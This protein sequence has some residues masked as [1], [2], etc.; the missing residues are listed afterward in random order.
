MSITDEG[1][2][3]NDPKDPSTLPLTIVVYLDAEP[4]VP[5][6]SP[7]RVMTVSLNAAHDMIRSPS[8]KVYGWSYTGDLKESV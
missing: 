8:W 5:G 2:I 6:I 1:S 4:T 3:L 7:R